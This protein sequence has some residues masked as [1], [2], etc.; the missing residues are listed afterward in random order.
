MDYETILKD[1]EIQIE[2]VLHSI[3]YK[4]ENWSPRN[5]ER[6]TALCL[7]REYLKDKIKEVARDELHKMNEALIRADIK[8][9]VMSEGVI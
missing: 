1:L 6:L 7:G 5:E 8:A 9:Q 3:V 4:D 2:G